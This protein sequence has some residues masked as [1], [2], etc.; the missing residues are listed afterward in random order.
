MKKLLCLS[1]A[2]IVSLSVIPVL[3]APSGGLESAISTVRSRIEVPAEL[4]EFSS[5]IT[6]SQNGADVYSLVWSTP[7]NA[8]MPGSLSVSIDQYGYILQYSLYEP[9]D[10]FDDYGAGFSKY[11]EDEL[12]SMAY[13]FFERLNPELAAEFPASYAE[14]RQS[15]GSD[16]A[17]V[18]L[19]RYIN[20]IA[21][22]GDCANIYIDKRSGAVDNMNVSLSYFSSIDS[23]QSVISAAAAAES[24][25]A[26]NPM[27]AEYVRCADGEA[28]ITY[29]PKDSGYMLDA[30]TGEQYVRKMYEGINAAFGSGGGASTDAA[31]AAA[32]GT[33]ELTEQELESIAQIEALLSEDELKA[34]AAGI[35]ETGISGLDY[36]SCTYRAGYSEEVYYATLRYAGG[37]DGLTL[38]ITLNAETGELVRIRGYSNNYTS[39]PELTEAQ[40]L[41]LAQA[42]A[43]KY[44]NDEY[45]KVDSD[46]ELSSEH[47]EDG[48]YS[49]YYFVFLRQENGIKY[50]ANY[51]S[52]T[53][54][55]LS[56]N[57]LGYSNNWDDSV[58]FRSPDGII[59]AGEAF[60]KLTEQVGLELEYVP[61]YED[62]VYNADLV[63]TLKDSLS[64]RVLAETGEIVG[65]DGK[66]VTESESSEI[67]DIYGHYA[68]GQIRALVDN[69]VL[70]LPEGET[71]FRP[72]ETITQ[73]D[74]LA[75][76]AALR[77]SYYRYPISDYDSVY[78]NSQRTGV[79]LPDEVKDS[80]SPCKREDGV[81]YIIRSLGYTEIAEMSDIF[82]PAFSDDNQITPGYEG[83]VAIAK[84]FGIVNGSP[85]NLFEPQSELTRA[86][87]AIMIYNYLAR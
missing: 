17:S 9:G 21:V 37:E 16:T 12:I 40:A 77:G 87:A 47:E 39:A 80:G 28:I 59:S 79:I 61:A 60:D 14:C 32:A 49:D 25:E 81:K 76:T 15:I 64:Y 67:T 31:E 51:I 36:V 7:D 53:V 22:S 20:N 86:D 38:S 63:Y 83:Y 11:T 73:G 45:A 34:A 74:M 13:E 84:G 85:G 43:G 23:P 54:D 30:Q 65:S 18:Q 78:L 19:Q 29:V 68:E 4:S 48:Y 5:D 82:E 69:G 46:T 2:W 56:G 52:V 57:I 3:A 24:F 33:P 35:T 58:T 62:G 72:D 26:N 6:A 55:R 71:E 27:A 70:I 50:P 1:L 75:F 8:A 41:E 42:F 44:A 66:P 10:V